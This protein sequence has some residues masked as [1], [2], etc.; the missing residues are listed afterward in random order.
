MKTFTRV[1]A[2]LMMVAMLATVMAACGNKAQTGGTTTDT[3][4]TNHVDNN[5]VGTWVQ[6]DETAGNW[7]WT[8]NADGTCKLVGDGFDSDGTY[9]I[10]EEGNGKIKI[11]LEK[12][13]KENVFTYTATEKVLDLEGFEDSY[14]CQKQ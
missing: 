7:T 11:T 10:P 6:T 8:F 5:L 12:W 2:V 1:I 13:G 14:Y 9:I 3:A 4:E